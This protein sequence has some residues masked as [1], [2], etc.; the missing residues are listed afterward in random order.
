MWAGPCLLL[1]LLEASLSLSGD[2][3][4]SPGV[5]RVLYRQGLW[6]G[7]VAAAQLAFHLVPGQDSA[8]SGI[9]SR[10]P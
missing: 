8:V 10:A 5:P 9:E 2:T 4:V 6:P 3:L 1:K 7:I